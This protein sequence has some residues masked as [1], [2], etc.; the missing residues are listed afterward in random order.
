MNIIYIID[1]VFILCVL[2]YN[3]ASVMVVTRLLP[4]DPH[5]RRA[6]TYGLIVC[7]GDLEES[8]TSFS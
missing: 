8:M 5:I 1:A 4:Q 3:C 2:L 6:E 7:D